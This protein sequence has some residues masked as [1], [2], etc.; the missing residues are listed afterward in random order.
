MIWVVSDA[1]VRLTAQQWGIE[2]I[3][4][5]PVGIRTVEWNNTSVMINGRAIYLRGF[6]RHEDSDVSKFVV[7]FHQF[8]VSFK[9]LMGSDKCI[10]ERIFS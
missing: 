4:R 7:K 8:A 10:I 1:Q 5:L 9:L 2:D 6:G 3:Y